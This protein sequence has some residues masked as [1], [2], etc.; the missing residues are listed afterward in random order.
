MSDVLS[1]RVNLVKNSVC[2][3]LVSSGKGYDLK[4]FR[5]S[6]E[7][8]DGIGSKANESCSLPS[9]L[10]WN[11]QSDIIGLAIVILAAEQSLVNIQQ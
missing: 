2:V 9:A 1:L 10:S 3:V 7:K 11:G 6:F 4:D 8:T 5:H